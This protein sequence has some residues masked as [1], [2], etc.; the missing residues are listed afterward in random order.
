MTEMRFFSAYHKEELRTQ[1]LVEVHYDA[2]GEV[3]LA[4][5]EQKAESE[6]R[7]RGP[8]NITSPRLSFG[9]GASRTRPAVL[10]SSPW[11]A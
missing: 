9:S 5:G 2:G 11:E 7:L 4:L 8:G 1:K 6:P 10:E 3:N